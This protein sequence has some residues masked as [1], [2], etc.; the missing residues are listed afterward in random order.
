MIKAEQKVTKTTA[1]RGPVRRTAESLCAATQPQKGSDEYR[2]ALLVIEMAGQAYPAG[3]ALDG[4][5][6]VQVSCTSYTMP[7][8][9]R[10]IRDEP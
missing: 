5:A 7:L 9:V 4:K 8:Q 2:I 1:G 6:L 3:F 10:T